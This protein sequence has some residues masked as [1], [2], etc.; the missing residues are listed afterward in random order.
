MVNTKTYFMKKIILFFAI[1]IGVTSC[2]SSEKAQ[3]EKVSTKKNTEMKTSDSSSN[4]ADIKWIN[5]GYDLEK[6]RPEGLKV[7]MKAPDFKL[8]SSEGES[9]RLS[10]ELKKQ[11]VVLIFYRG[12]WCP[13]CTRYLSGLQ[14]NL[15]KIVAKGAKVIAITPETNENIAKTIE[16]A[17]TD[18]T[19][20]SDVDMSV[21]GDYK[22]LFSVTDDYQDKIRTKLESD[23]AFNNGKTEAQLPVPAT[24][25]I[26]QDGVIKFAQ[27]DLDYNSRASADDI[28]KHL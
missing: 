7:G 23:I 2:N 8:N 21:T 5:M 27:F 4:D 13:V 11:P 26:G 18:F 24:Y 12:Q 25:V 14:E 19:I 10:D 16:K 28:V 22:G 17:G 3:K 9:V 20:L 15:P 1:V 6:G